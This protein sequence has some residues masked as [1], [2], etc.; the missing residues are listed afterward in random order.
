[1]DR[2]EKQR[3]LQELGG[4]SEDLYDELIGNLISQVHEQ[5]PKLKG[6]LNNDDYNGIAES[7][8]FIKGSAGN[9]RIHTIHN[10]AKS[11]EE[12]ASQDKKDR[13]AIVNALRKLEE[14]LAQLE[15][16]S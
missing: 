16:E 2:A 7:A 9:L 11:I 1:M 3:I 4:I 12:A 14:S 5:I 6:C 15:K 8:H 10:I 13:N